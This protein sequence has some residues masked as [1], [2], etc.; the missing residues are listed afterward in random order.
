MRDS[1]GK[2]ATYVRAARAMM[3]RERHHG[4]PDK[5]H[6]VSTSFR[7]LFSSWYPQELV[8]AFHAYETG[9]GINRFCGKPPSNM[10]KVHVKVGNGAWPYP[11]SLRTR[12]QRA[13]WHGEAGSAWS[14]GT[15]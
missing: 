5:H 13:A 3:T 7:R 4:Y 9:D 15:T 14:S 12:R 8:S 1:L 11:T 6:R 10:D 2:T